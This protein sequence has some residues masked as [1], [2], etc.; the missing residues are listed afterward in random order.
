MSNSERVRKLVIIAVLGAVSVVLG[1]TRLGLIP[2]FS[3]ASLTIIHVPVIVALLLEGPL[4]GMAVGLIFGVVSLVQAATGSLGPADVFFVNPLVS[5]LPR[6]LFPL[7]S[8]GVYRLLGG[9]V[10]KLAL[11]GASFM[12][13]L[14]H[15]FLVLG[16]LTLVAELPLVTLWLILGANGIPEAVAAAI[17]ST[18]LVL[19]WRKVESRKGERA[20]LVELEED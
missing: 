17:I 19:K 6:V 10:K 7:F 3:G 9:G 8:W 12:G 13:S 4:V 11:V 15:T 14:F 5:V 1:V 16:A 18:T 20:K 2:W